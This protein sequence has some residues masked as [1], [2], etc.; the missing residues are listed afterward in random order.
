MIK[1]GVRP[2]HNVVS[3]RDLL[4]IHQHKSKM[5]NAATSKEMRDKYLENVKKDGDIHYFKKTTFGPYF[6][7]QVYYLV[8]NKLFL[9]CRQ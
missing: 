2:I 3:T 7:K 4:E 9:I 6:Q 8:I 5:D 1:W